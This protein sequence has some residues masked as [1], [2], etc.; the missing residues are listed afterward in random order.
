M[1]VNESSNERTQRRLARPLPVIGL[2]ATV[3]VTLAAGAL[4]GSSAAFAA[5]PGLGTAAPYSVLRATTVS[6]TGP[7]VL[8]GELGDS[9]GSTLTGFSTAPVGGVPRRRRGHTR[10][11][12]TISA[13]QTQAAASLAASEVATL[14]SL[15]LTLGW[16]PFASQLESSVHVNPEH[17]PLRTVRDVNGRSSND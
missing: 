5:G 2:G 14:S 8:S 10:S 13:A 7:S 9:P 6:N 15:L 12:R 3:G 16:W 1:T 4:P 11:R 17:V